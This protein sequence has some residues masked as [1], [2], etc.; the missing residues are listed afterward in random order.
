MFTSSFPCSFAGYVRLLQR[1]EYIVSLNKLQRMKKFFI[2]ALF[3]LCAALPSM[4][5]ISTGTPTAK[6]I[7]TGNRPQAGDFGLY[8]GAT[9]NMFKNLTDKDIKMDPLPLLNFKYMITNNLEARIGLEFSRTRETVKPETEVEDNEKTY[10]LS[11]KYKVVESSNHINPGLA[12]HFNSKNILDVYVGVEATVGWSRNSFYKDYAEYM[13]EGRIDEGYSNTRKASFQLGAGA[14][15]GI[16]AFIADLPLAIGVEYGLSTL[17]DT[18]LRYKNESQFGD[19]DEVVTY[20]TDMKDLPKL[21]GKGIEL[22]GDYTALKA[23]KGTIG[24][25]FRITLSYYF[26]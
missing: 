8:L 16:Q 1:D 2:T 24:N 10:T 26:K 7:R 11:S 18:R 14:F 6:K 4:A 21:A 22:N 19:G 20:T 23:N 15:I 13:G 5:Q 3:A 12:Y 9:S 17:F 25:Q